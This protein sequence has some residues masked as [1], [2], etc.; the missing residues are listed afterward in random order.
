MKYDF[1]QPELDEKGKPTYRKFE[2]C[3]ANG[4]RWH[5]VRTCDTETGE[6][7]FVVFDYRGEVVFNA[8]RTEIKE[9]YVKTAGPLRITPIPYK[10]LEDPDLDFTE[11]REG[12]E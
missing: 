6:L 1:S 8:D 2:L 9:D 11:L 3:D 7:T 5:H 4:L 12:K 10:S